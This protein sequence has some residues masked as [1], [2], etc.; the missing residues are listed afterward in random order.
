M[1][2]RKHGVK[3]VIN[4]RPRPRKVVVVWEYDSYKQVEQVADEFDDLKPAMDQAMALLSHPMTRSVSIA[5][6]E[7]EVSDADQ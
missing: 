1:P 5:V 6:P 7:W 2:Y 3:R 4:P